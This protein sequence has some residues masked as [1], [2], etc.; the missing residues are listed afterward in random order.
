MKG[1]WL[2]WWASFLGEVVKAHEC[3]PQVKTAWRK[4]RGRFTSLTCTDWARLWTPQMGFCGSPPYSHKYLHWDVHSASKSTPLCPGAVMFVGIA[5]ITGNAGIEGERGAQ[6]EP[7]EVKY[8]MI[9]EVALIAHV[10]PPLSIKGWI[11]HA[12]PHCVG[13]TDDLD[14]SDGFGKCELWAD[15]FS[16][17]SQLHYEWW[18]M[19]V[20]QMLQKRR[21]RSLPE[22]YNNPGVIFGKS[23]YGRFLCA[24]ERKIGKDDSVSYKAKTD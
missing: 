15:C 11:M 19:L 23:Y 14:Y 1:Y 5:R 17:V 21:Q 4:R 10:W 12:F 16:V 8:V 2:A 18:S 9:D 3:L 24:E 13:T 7:T 6:S 20:L 22:A